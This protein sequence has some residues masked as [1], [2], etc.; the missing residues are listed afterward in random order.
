MGK[1]CGYQ[2]VQCS[3]SQKKRVF[4]DLLEK[5]QKNYSSF[6]RL[7]KQEKATIVIYLILSLIWNIFTLVAV[8]FISVLNDTLVECIFIVSAFGFLRKHLVNLFT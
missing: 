8:F 6:K 1:I 7:N 4:S 5:L 2:V 3:S